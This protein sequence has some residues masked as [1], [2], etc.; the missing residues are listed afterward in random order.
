MKFKIPKEPGLKH[1]NSITNG[2]LMTILFDDTELDRMF[3]LLFERCVKKGEIGPPRKQKEFA[4]GGD[5]NLE[6]KLIPALS[7]NKALVGFDSE[8]GREI[9]KNWSSTSVIQFNTVGKTKQGSQ[10]DF[11]KFL[12]IGGYR[13]GLPK[14]ENRSSVRQIDSTFYRNLVSYLEKLPGCEKPREEI[15]ASVTSTSLAVGL[16]FDPMKQPWKSPTYNEKDEIDINTLLELRILENFNPEVARATKSKS[17]SD[18]NL[19]FPE[20]LEDLS[21][22]FYWI[23]NAFKNRSSSE[24]LAMYKSIFSLRL[25]RLPILFAKKLKSYSIADYDAIA[26]HEMFF[27]FTNL[28]KSASYDLAVQN[29]IE[30]VN[31]AS[32]YLYFNIYLREAEQMIRKI[33]SRNVEFQKLNPEER[34]KYL[35]EFAKSETAIDKAYDL[36]EVF[37][38]FYDESNPDYEES[39]RIIDACEKDNHFDSLIEVILSAVRL[40]GNSSLRKWFYS[41]GGLKY[42]KSAN[43]VA[44]LG[45]DMRHITGWHYTMSDSVLNTLLHMCFLDVNGKLMGRNYLTMQEVLNRLRD[46]FG[47]VIA[48]PPTG[49]ETIQNQK[50]ATEN[51]IAFKKR[52]RQL[53]WFEGLSDDFDA[54]H[55]TKPAGDM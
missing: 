55:I 24:L 46:R 47:V 36:L 14:S 19:P 52:L 28:K 22:D 26:D 42:E 4:P 23:T 15:H 20:I 33:N 34:V 35:F 29:V 17:E 53:G 50:A 1:M 51:F 16:E 45:G 43:T 44:I 32:Q 41:V 13:A 6:E 5:L 7:T 12:T 3:A 21:R 40:R 18:S 30:D 2:S 25:Y 37:R 31:F 48:I 39:N 10:I 8:R 11:M 38:D 54:Q 9:L 49:F 27:D